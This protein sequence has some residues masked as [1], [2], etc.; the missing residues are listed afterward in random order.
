MQNYSKLKYCPKCSSSLEN[1]TESGRLRKI[2]SRCS[3][4]L[5]RNPIP[6]ANIIIA[7]DK[8]EIVL[9]KRA[10]EPK[11]G[12][13]ALPG[14]YV[15]FDENPKK[16][17]AREAFEETGLK[18]EI[19]DLVDVYHRATIDEKFVIPIVY[20]AK[21]AGGTLRPGD[22]IEDVNF[23]NLDRLPRLAFKHNTEA[24]KKWRKK[25]GR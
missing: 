9:G 24:I 17:A 3:Y 7:N 15:E 19:T 1:K 18:V 6:V 4:I 22:D 16:T 14:G 12:E 23:Y 25:H 20:S 8:N 5:Y 2:C 21:I 10:I 11:K 13:W